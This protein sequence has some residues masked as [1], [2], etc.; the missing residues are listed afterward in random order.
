MWLEVEG[1]PAVEGG[2]KAD[3][4]FNG[5]VG[6]AAEDLGHVGGRDAC[7][8]SEFGAGEVEAFKA[9]EDLLG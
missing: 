1:E 3:E 9:F 6:L 2:G 7:A 8:A 4:R 5:E